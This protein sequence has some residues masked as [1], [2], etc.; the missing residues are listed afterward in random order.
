M[1]RMRFQE[2]RMI[3]ANLIVF[4]EDNIQGFQILLIFECRRSEGRLPSNIYFI[5]SL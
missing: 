4:L 2:P 1:K 3:I 5:G